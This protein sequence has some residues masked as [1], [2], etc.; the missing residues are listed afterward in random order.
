MKFRTSQPR[1]SKSVISK[2]NTKSDIFNL[3]NDKSGTNKINGFPVVVL[4]ESEFAINLGAA[5]L[6][7]FCTEA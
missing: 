4:E 7:Q 2:N 1:H 3:K 5:E 6:G